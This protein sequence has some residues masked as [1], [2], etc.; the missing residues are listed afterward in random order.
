MKAEQSQIEMNHGMD[1]FHNLPSS[2]CH[3][4]NAVPEKEIAMNIFDC[5][6]KMEEKPDVLRKTGNRRS[7]VEVSSVCWRQ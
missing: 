1:K 3:D 5:A 7:R 2:I 6:I 4:Y